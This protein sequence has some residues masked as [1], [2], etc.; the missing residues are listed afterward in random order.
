MNA[1]TGQLTDP[2]GWETLEL[3]ADA[4]AFNRWL[5]DRIYPFCKGQVLEVGS[6]IGNISSLLLDKHLKVSLSDLRPEYCRYL[7][8]Q[9]VSNP[10]LQGVYQMDLSI[11]DFENRY[12]ALIN[13]FGTVI[14]L[15][16][17]E[18]IEQD[19]LAVHNAK[20]LLRTGG[21][22]IIL[23]PAGKRLY[24]NFDRELGH[25]RRYSGKTLTGL[26]TDTGLTVTHISYFNFTG[27]LGW[28]FS[29][30]VLKKKMIPRSQL[31]LYNQLVPVFRIIDRLFV[32]FAGLSVI[33]VTTN[34]AT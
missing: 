20:K 6:G 24:N 18:H 29:G 33:A 10:D 27:I 8:H 7:T 28:W 9:F 3:F 15:N 4:P 25:Y 23:V 19:M 11:P 13:R 12:P 1:R 21:N 30:S 26:L 34:Q 16:V 32:R 2:S 31:K 22:L 14:A 17:V 5:F